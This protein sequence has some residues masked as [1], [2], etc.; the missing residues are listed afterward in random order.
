[1]PV[2]FERLFIVFIIGILLVGV[3]WSFGQAKDGSPGGW[4]V[5]ILA[6]IGVVYILNKYRL[7]RIW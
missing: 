3:F 2:E 6:I 4:V 7:I 5:L 1:M